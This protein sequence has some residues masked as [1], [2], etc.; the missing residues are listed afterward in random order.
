MNYVVSLIDRQTQQP[1]EVTL[2]ESTLGYTWIKPDGSDLEHTDPQPRII[3]AR[4]ELERKYLY[5]HEIFWPQMIPRNRNPGKDKAEIGFSIHLPVTLLWE[6][7]LLAGLQGKKVGVTIR[8][9][10]QHYIRPG[11]LP[12]LDEAFI[13]QIVEQNARKCKTP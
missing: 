13:N 7:K 4:R 10:L 8:D 6:L 2:Q 3:Q 9:I 11:T 12:P 5:T 1:Q